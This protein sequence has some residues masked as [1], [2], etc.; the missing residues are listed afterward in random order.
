MMA[1]L[2]Y[3]LSMDYATQL[4]NEF[5]KS[6]VN[7]NAVDGISC[8]RY[9]SLVLQYTYEKKCILVPDNEETTTFL[10]FRHP[11]TVDAELFPTVARIPDAMLHKV[12]PSHP[13]LVSYLKTINLDIEIGVLLTIT[14]SP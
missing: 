13:V 3:D 14:T 6:V 11:K 4:Q 9:Q 1:G 7:T 5:V 10:V 8:A 2:Y 12:D